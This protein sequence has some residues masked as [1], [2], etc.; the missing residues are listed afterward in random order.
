MANIS[1]QEIVFGPLYNSQNVAKIP[2]GRTYSMSNASMEDGIVEGGPR[3]GDVWS[4]AGWNAG[5]EGLGLFYAEYG[6]TQEYLAVIRHNAEAFARLYKINVTT[7]VWTQVTGSGGVGEPDL[8][9]LASSARYHFAQ[10]EN[11]VYITTE[12]STQPMLK[13][14]VGGANGTVDAGTWFVP[15]Y[16]RGTVG[17]EIEVPPEIETPMGKVTLVT[18]P[19][20]VTLEY[21][22]AS[23]FKLST[24]GAVALG[25]IRIVMDLPAELDLQYSDW[26]HLYYTLTGGAGTFLAGT[27]FV[28]SVSSDG[29]SALTAAWCDNQRN[30]YGLP[31]NIAANAPSASKEI[32]LTWGGSLIAP[33]DR[34]P[35]RRIIWTGS[36]GS[37]VNPSAVSFD[38]ILIG[39][40]YL[41]DIAAPGP[42]ATIGYACR[43]GKTKKATAEWTGLIKLPALLAGDLRGLQV[44]ASGVYTG[45]KVRVSVPFSST[46]YNQG[47]NKVEF[48]RESSTAA[49]DYYSLGTADHKENTDIFII[50]TVLQSVVNAGATT[51][52]LAPTG[53][54]SSCG[55]IEVWKQHLVLHDDRKL[56]FSFAGLPD[57]F[58]PPKSEIQGTYATNDDDL[59]RTVFVS[60]GQ[61]LAAFTM[62]GA[63]NFYVGT[64]RNVEFLIGDTA[65]TATPPRQA[66]GSFGAISTFGACL[67]RN[68]AV[69]AHFPGLYYYNVTRAYAQSGDTPQEDPGQELTIEVRE[70]WKTAVSNSYT[71]MVVTTYEDEIWVFVPIAGDDMYMRLCRPDPVTGHRDWETGTW[72]KVI[73]AAPAKGLGLRVILDNGKV[74]RVGTNST[75]ARYTTDDG[76]AVN[77][78][79]ATGE[80]TTGRERVTGIF[81]EGSGT[82]TITVTV[83]DGMNTAGAGVD[84]V[85]T[86][87]A[88]RAWVQSVN[89]LPGMRFKVTVTGVVGTDK[90]RTLVLIKESE[91]PGKG[92]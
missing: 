45:V 40:L 42:T 4:R 37:G 8:Q 87:E 85:L 22:G 71:F 59:G 55:L 24:A 11:Y 15:T 16:N 6:T 41:W 84:Y 65:N 80:M 51:P 57:Q 60:P 92:N 70:T 91:G 68:G 39:G 7:G 77:W 46:L 79:V 54:S 23:G 62:V 76:A 12:D 47:Y 74:I 61:T 31:L 78:S 48:F 44:L 19:A 90:L 64:K 69:I 50:D 52:T 83:W 28:T 49:G 5:D 81:W 30:G 34:K 10:Y 20:G 17:A 67:Y 63:D 21:S 66:P 38:R 2:E 13:R 33:K 88:G 75:G 1:E 73:A 86:T 35:I 56:Y 18:A 27:G 26:Y 43:F 9:S 53:P 89:I 29:D 14:K 32:G 82:P 58:R 36:Y 3:Y 25:A 72:P